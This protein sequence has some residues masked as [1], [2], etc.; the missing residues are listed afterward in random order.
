VDVG[1]NDIL[2]QYLAAMN[3]GAVMPIHHGSN[4]KTTT[5]HDSDGFRSAPPI[6][7]AASY[8]TPNGN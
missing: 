7:T 3:S 8:T 1:S 5:G 6:V 4:T 2:Q